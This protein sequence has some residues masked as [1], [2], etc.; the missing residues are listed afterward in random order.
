MKKI[1]LFLQIVF[2]LIV[3]AGAAYKSVV[4]YFAVQE[5]KP[6]LS[7]DWEMTFSYQACA[8]P[9]LAFSGVEIIYNLKITQN[10]RELKATGYKES[11]KEKGGK[12]A[13][14]PKSAQDKIVIKGNLRN[15]CWIGKSFITNSDDKQIIGDVRID[16]KNG[17]FIYEGNYFGGKKNDCDGLL[18]LKRKNM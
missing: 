7:G 11:H 5:D 15:G 1:K 17:H 14:Y 10:E 13:P 18:R 4:N 9:D 3:I 6:S 16:F 2:L 8:N 12:I